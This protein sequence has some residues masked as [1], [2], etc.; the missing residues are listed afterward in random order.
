[1]GT[2]FL[3]ITNLHAEIA[4]D[5]GR[6]R[7]RTAAGGEA[8]DGSR[9]VLPAFLVRRPLAGAWKFRVGAVSAN[10]QG[11]KHQTPTLLYN[12]MIHPLLDFP[13]AGVIWY[14]GES[15]AN[16]V[17]DAVAIVVRPRTTE[18]RALVLPARGVACRNPDGTW[19][20]IS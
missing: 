1:M 4:E 3:K 15:N 13:V 11:Q 14:Q 8:S 5:G 9:G 7:I 19:S 17:E 6:M 12:Q 20:Q 16:T 2:T 18:V 10:P